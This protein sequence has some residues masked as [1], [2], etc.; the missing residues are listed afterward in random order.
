VRTGLSTLTELADAI[1]H[2]D[3]PSTGRRARCRHGWADSP[4][5]GPGCGPHCAHCRPTR[6]RTWSR[7]PRR[8]RHISRGACS[9]AGR[10]VLAVA[11]RVQTGPAVGCPATPTPYTT[12]GTTSAPRCCPAATPRALHGGRRRRR[13]P[14]GGAVQ[15]DGMPAGASGVVLSHEFPRIPHAVDG[16]MTFLVKSRMV[17][18]W[19]PSYDPATG[20]SQRHIPMGSRL[21]VWLDDCRT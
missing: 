14:G 11:A 5:G 2:V 7:D 1:R 13:D 15:R 18:P 16:T 12:T 3:T 20:L 4:G 17:A 9:T 21:A 6:P 8:R 19:S 10:S